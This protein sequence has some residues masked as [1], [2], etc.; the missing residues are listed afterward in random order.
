MTESRV[1]VTKPWFDNIRVNTPI[2]ITDEQMISIF[3]RIPCCQNPPVLTVNEWE[4]FKLFIGQL[5]A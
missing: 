2:T 4:R 1:V 5:N 3:G